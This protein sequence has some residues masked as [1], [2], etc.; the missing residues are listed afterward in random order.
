MKISKED[1]IK[2][3]TAAIVWDCSD[4]QR[5]YYVK[6]IIAGW[7]RRGYI[8]G[9]DAVKISGDCCESNESKRKR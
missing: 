2:L 5:E 4:I 9:V 3:A 8:E 1:A 6:E 7:G